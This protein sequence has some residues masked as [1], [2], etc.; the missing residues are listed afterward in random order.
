[1][2]RGGFLT[3]KCLLE[4]VVQACRELGATVS[5]EYPVRLGQTRGF[6]DLRV[7]FGPCRV[8]I[9][10]ELGPKRLENDLHK[11]MALPAYLLLVVVPNWQ[12][13]G[14]ARKAM[15][16]ILEQ[17]RM[18]GLLA[19]VEP[20]TLILPVGPA[21]QQLRQINDFVTRSLHDLSQNHKIIPARLKQA[22]SGPRNER[23]KS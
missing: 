21:I 2:N 22:L 5:A 16:R 19:D 20:A 3:R 18:N 12:S 17:R 15:A 6:V 13:C 14:T 1:M 4:P 23:S 8:A 10:A 11:A 7:D 9:E